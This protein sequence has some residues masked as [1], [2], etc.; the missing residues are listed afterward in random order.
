MSRETR[1]AAAVCLYDH[2]HIV[3]AAGRILRRES[4]GELTGL[5]RYDLLLQIAPSAPGPRACYLL[6]QRP[7]ITSF[8]SARLPGPEALQAVGTIHHVTFQVGAQQR[9]GVSA[10]SPRAR[11][12]LKA[13]GISELR[14]PAPPADDREVT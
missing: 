14:P 10:A 3:D 11:A 4:R 12:V 8:L 9:C 6:R 2:F 5:L 1:I 13:L 7:L